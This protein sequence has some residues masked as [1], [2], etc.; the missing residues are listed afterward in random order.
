MY[1]SD[2]NPECDYD[3]VE[4]WLQTNGFSDLQVQ[5][6]FMKISNANPQCDMKV[7]YCAAGSS[8]SN[9]DAYLAEKYLGD[10]LRYLKCCELT[11]P[12]SS[13]YPNL[14][15]VFLTSRT[16]G[17]YSNGTSHQCLNPEPFA[18]E[19]AFAVQRAI[20]AQIDQTNSVSD[21]DPYS[22]Q[23]DYNNAPWFD[24][25][26][27]LWASGV[28][29]SPGT[30]LFWCDTTNASSQICINHNDPGDFRWGDPLDEITY[31]GD[32]THPSY[33]AEARVAG[34]LVKFIQ[35]SLGPAQYFISDWVKPWVLP[36]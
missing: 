18:Y 24:W 27:Y 15:Q 35:G 7:L 19:G 9:S 28:N 3:R 13:R 11:P 16:Y 4:S 1:G 17:G 2:F 36:H 31:W 29:Q 21:T 34:Q 20:V 8:E 26:P 12:N 6:V 5:A 10:V 14:Q 22:G 25:G 33:S 32:H 23:L 30:G